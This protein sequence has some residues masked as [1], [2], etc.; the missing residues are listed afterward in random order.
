MGREKLNKPRGRG[1]GVPRLVDFANMSEESKKNAV[2]SYILSA[3][4][5][6]WRM[7]SELTEN[8]YGP[9]TIEERDLMDLPAPARADAM[10]QLEFYATMQLPAQAAIDTRE[11]AAR[12]AAN[13]SQALARLRPL[14]AGSS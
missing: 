3:N 13:A 11:A 7:L 9:F 5:P 8:K 6:T 10:N 2:L 14:I 1:K 4:D 12:T